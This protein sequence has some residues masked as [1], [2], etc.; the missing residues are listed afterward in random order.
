MAYVGI[1][2][3]ELVLK[4]VTKKTQFGKALE[5]V[6]TFGIK[7]DSGEEREVQVNTTCTP[8]EFLGS[9]KFYTDLENEG[10]IFYDTSNKYRI[11]LLEQLKKADVTEMEIL[12]Q[13]VNFSEDVRMCLLGDTLIIGEALRLKVAEKYKH[14][15][16]AQKVSIPFEFVLN[17]IHLAPQCPVLLAYVAVSVLEGYFATEP[18]NFSRFVCVME[19]RT[20]AYKSTLARLVT[21]YDFQ[22]NVLTL[23]SSKASLEA[24]L[25]GTENIPVLLDDFNLS[26]YSCGNSRKG[27]ILT[28]IIQAFTERHAIER[29]NGKVVTSTSMGGGIFVTA[30]KMPLNH[31]TLNR[32]LI[33]EVDL[34]TPINM[35]KL[36]ILQA[37]GQCAMSELIIG[38]NQYI[39][40]N[41]DDIREVHQAQ[42]KAYRD[43]KTF[44]PHN[45]KTVY[46]YSRILNT[47]AV[48][49]SAAGIMCKFF[50]DKLLDEELVEAC[51]RMMFSGI[52]SACDRLCERLSSGAEIISSVLH[53]FLHDVEEKSFAYSEDEYYKKINKRI[54]IL[55]D[56]ILYIEGKR[57]DGLI[58]LNMRE[59]TRTQVIKSL[60]SFS[61]LCIDSEGRK[62]IHLPGGKRKARY[63]AIRY[64]ELQD[65]IRKQREAYSDYIYELEQSQMVVNEEW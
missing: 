38:F 59:F 31:S 39:L 12:S 33:V 49:Q 18:W 45:D 48:T 29:K 6:L 30:E 41:Y 35:E 22:Q 5:T 58:S 62:S 9:K 60:E 11:S 26:S 23:G 57:I 32:C 50:R 8:T 52:R 36:S 2:S 21:K 20:G 63:Y 65:I 1:T 10:V 24:R 44:F 28:E 55:Q 17:F 4:E 34:D 16:L 51:R 15:K 7:E 19:G 47:Y 27:N 46:G 25:G 42:I 64:Y 54:G 14:Y 61:L 37:Q 3:P 56:K 43:K 13:G 53:Y 40:D